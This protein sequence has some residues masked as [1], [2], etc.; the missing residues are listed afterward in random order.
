MTQR[1]GFFW[2][3]GGTNKRPLSHNITA[4]FRLVYRRTNKRPLSHDLTAA[5]RSVYT[6]NQ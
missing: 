4:A 3:I 6:K 5:I 2:Y 1:P